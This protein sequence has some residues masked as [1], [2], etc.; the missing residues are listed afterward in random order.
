[1]YPEEKRNYSQRFR[2]TFISLMRTKSRTAPLV[3]YVK[4]SVLPGIHVPMRET[5]Q[6]THMA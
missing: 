2:D 3:I 6:P 5:Q 1:M 4:Q